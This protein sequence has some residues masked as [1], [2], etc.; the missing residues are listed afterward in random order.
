MKFTTNQSIKKPMILSRNP[1]NYSD[2]SF[3]LR[4]IFHTFDF[5]QSVSLT[6]YVV[7]SV[8]LS[9]NLPAYPF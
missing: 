6:Q 9:A 7:L 1:E 5:S 4:G 3:I 8:H 2:N